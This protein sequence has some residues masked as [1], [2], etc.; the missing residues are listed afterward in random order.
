[1]DQDDAFRSVEDEREQFRLA[2]RRMENEH[3]VTPASRVAALVLAERRDVVQ[4]ILVNVAGE[5]L[6]WAH[7]P[8]Q[9]PQLESRVRDGVTGRGRR[10]NLMNSHPTQ[11]MASRA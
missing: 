9:R 6:R 2:D 7:S 1:V 8:K 10:E 11:R 5:Q 3:V 4:E